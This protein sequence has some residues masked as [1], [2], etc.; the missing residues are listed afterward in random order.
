MMKPVPKF[1]MDSI[2]NLFVKNKTTY[3]AEEFARIFDL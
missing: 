2:K 1:V 3:T